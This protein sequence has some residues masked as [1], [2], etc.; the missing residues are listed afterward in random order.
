MKYEEPFTQQYSV[1][2]QKTNTLN[3]A[4]AKTPPSTFNCDK[5][6]K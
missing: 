6:K 4:I 2:S 1:T 3:Y 5:K